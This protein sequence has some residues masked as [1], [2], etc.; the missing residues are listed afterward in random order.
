MTRAERKQLR[1][2]ARVRNR[3]E[4]LRHLDVHA[5]RRL[6]AKY[7]RWQLVTTTYSVGR[8]RVT[9][10]ELRSPHWIKRHGGTR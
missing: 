1:R 10:M 8:F 2:Q 3:R 7:R 4:W 6:M 9:S 5:A